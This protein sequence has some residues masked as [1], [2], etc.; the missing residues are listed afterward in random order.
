VLTRDIASMRRLSEDG[1]IGEDPI[2]IG[3]IH[4]A[5]GRTQILPYVFLNE[6][7]RAELLRLAEAGASI[8]ARDLPGTRPIDLVRIL[9]ERP[10]D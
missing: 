3:G 7:E 2:N 10:H 8:D 5:P 1:P 9:A 6:A 4:Y